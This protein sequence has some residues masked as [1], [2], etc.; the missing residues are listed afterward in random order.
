MADFVIVKSEGGTIDAKD[1]YVDEG[2]P[3]MIEYN[4]ERGTK[5]IY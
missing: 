2:D 4:S 1:E 5:Q 3:L